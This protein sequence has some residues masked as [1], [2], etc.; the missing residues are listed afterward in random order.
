[1]SV[2]CVGRLEV[3]LLGRELHAARHDAVQL[4][5]PLA[6]LLGVPELLLDVLLEV[7][8][9]L[10]GPHAVR[11]DRVRD[12]AHHGLDLHPVRLLQHLDQLLALLRVLLG[13]DAGLARDLVSTAT[14]STSR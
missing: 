11:V 4:L 1:M 9:D 5:D 8:D 6:E 10:A 2:C 14:C 3:G 12:V 13:E 7:L